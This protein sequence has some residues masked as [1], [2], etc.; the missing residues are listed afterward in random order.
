M[1]KGTYERKILNTHTE[2]FQEQ[3][4]RSYSQYQEGSYIPV[5]YYQVDKNTS[6]VDGSLDM[7]QNIIGTSSSRK[8]KKII[9]VPLYGLAGGINYELELSETSFKN[10]AS[11]QGYLAPGTVKPSADDFFTIDRQGLKNHL[12]KVT[13]IDFNTANANKYYQINFE[14][15]Q[16]SASEITGNISDEYKFLIENMGSNQNTI[17]KKSDEYIMS[18]CKEVTDTL[19]D[20]YTASF[21]DYAY[22]S[23]TVRFKFLNDT[24]VTK[25]WNPY[26]IRFMHDQDIVTKY[27]FDM[28]TEIFVPFYSEGGYE[29]WF[30][31][32]IWMDS[33]YNKIVTRQKIDP[34]D[35]FTHVD[36]EQSLTKWIKLPFYQSAETILLDSFANEYTKNYL[37][38][39]TETMHA[40]PLANRSAFMNIKSIFNKQIDLPGWP[41]KSMYLDSKNLLELEY[42]SANGDSII[43]TANVGDIFYVYNRNS[44]LI[45]NIY[46]IINIPGAVGPDTDVIQKDWKLL[47]TYVVNDTLGKIYN[48]FDE[49]MNLV[50]SWETVI[51]DGNKF[52]GRNDGMMMSSSSAQIDNLV[53]N[54]IRGY[55][56]KQNILTESILNELNLVNIRRDSIDSY[57]LI[58]IVIFILKDYVDKI[59]R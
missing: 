25:L 7:A 23:F 34:I 9:G 8:Y 14:L 33:I 52:I 39:P 36:T 56:N 28:M 48:F 54:I 49:D 51:V 22:D 30:K 24:T 53:V 26:L 2:V 55:H 27:E 59:Q 6:R 32:D 43:E 21:Y 17:I 41:S 13:S 38:I 11:S 5:I 40:V 57:Y 15:Y 10:M 4:E 20:K 42:L 44:N 1:A 12:F 16:N 35:I 46:E 31:D 47:D 37:K 58:P 19:I 3:L 50:S 18:L 45:E 29:F